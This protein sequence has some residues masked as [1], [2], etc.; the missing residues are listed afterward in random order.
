ENPMPWGMILGNG[1]LWLFISIFFSLLQVWV[2]IVY[3]FFGEMNTSNDKFFLDGTILFF[4][5]GIVVSSAFDIWV[6]DEKYLKMD[7][8][9]FILFHMIFPMVLVVL[10]TTMYLGLFR[11]ENLANDIKIIQLSSVICSLVY[12]TG[13]KY[14]NTASRLRLKN[15]RR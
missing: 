6:E 8:R 1:M 12:S 15:S 9:L 10:V 5:S 3:N 11:K 4:C 14:Q 2:F 13:S 7:K